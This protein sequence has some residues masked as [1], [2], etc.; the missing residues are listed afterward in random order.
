MATPKCIISNIHGDVTVAIDTDGDIK[1]H[2]GGKQHEG[3]CNPLGSLTAYLS[4]A[5]AAELANDLYRAVI[6]AQAKPAPTP[7]PVAGEAQT[8]E[9]VADEV[10]L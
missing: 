1:L 10:F 9:P 6:A 7:E 5:A 3:G 2:I 8:P 4:H